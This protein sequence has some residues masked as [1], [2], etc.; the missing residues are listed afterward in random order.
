MKSA[1]DFHA[2]EKCTKWIKCIGKRRRKKKETHK[3]SAVNF[4]L[5]KKQEKKEIIWV[6]INQ[7]EPF[8]TKLVR[9]TIRNFFRWDTRWKLFISKSERRCSSMLYNHIMR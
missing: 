9:E 3:F 6:K 7:R 5:S 2:A 4:F 1:I 8:E